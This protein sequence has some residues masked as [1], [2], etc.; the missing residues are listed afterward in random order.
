MPSALPE[1]PPPPSA[2]QPPPGWGVDELTKYI[3]IAR[4]NQWATFANKPIVRQ[5]LIAIDAQLVAVSKD[6]LNPQSEIAASL[7][8][9]CHSAFR[10]AAGHAL[11]GEVAD[12]FPSC[13]AMLEY[14]A[15]A[16]HVYRAPNLGMVWLKRHDDEAATEAQKNA[17]SHR[18]VFAAVKKAN[19]HAGERF[20]DLYQKTID[21]GGHPNQRAI[22]GNLEVVEVKGR[23][24]MRSILQHADGL[25]LDFGLTAVA[26]CGL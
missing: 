13:R 5:K 7:L 20:E 24:V 16:V 26:R 4:H 25:Q 11:A 9:R 14:A 6:W 2:E 21:F 22:L 12:C 18:K 1:P 19:R 15:Y 23:R 3:D 17:F 8:L 10:A